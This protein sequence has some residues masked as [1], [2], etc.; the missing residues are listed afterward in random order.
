MSTPTPASN[1]KY[2]A[3]RVRKYQLDL[4]RYYRIPV[5]QASLN[6]VMSLFIAAFFI[7]FAL[8]PTFITILKLQKT[9]ADSQVTYKTLE[10]KV[11]ALQ[12]AA[13]SLETL[14]PE[15][16]FIDASIPAKEAGYTPLIS[17]ME[18]LAQQHGVTLITSTLGET[19][20][21]SRIFS[22]FTPNKNQTL[23]SLPFSARVVGSYQAVSQFLHSVLNMDR[24]INV[25]SL[26]Y[27]REGNTKGSTVVSTSLTITG[28]AYYLADQAQLLKAMPTIKKGG[29]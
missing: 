3:S 28:E 11:A 24:V 4:S 12:K 7:L 8:R 16:P 1:A 15:L 14:A 17:S 25:E 10:A 26:T 19:V 13:K 29:K 23:V 27:A 2:E 22:P 5:V 18:V 21:Y 20:L 9:I 6:V